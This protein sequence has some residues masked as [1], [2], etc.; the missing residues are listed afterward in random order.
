MNFNY[1]GYFQTYSG[2]G[3]AQSLGN[4]EEGAHEILE[5]LIEFDWLDD[6]TRAVVLEFN[7]YNPHV[8]LFSLV[9]VLC[10]FPSLGAALVKSDV[11]I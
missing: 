8:N 9:T 10:E 3:Y 1:P 11:C 6:Y 7:V 4:T 5:E 2:R